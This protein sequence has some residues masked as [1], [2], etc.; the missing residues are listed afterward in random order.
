VL[1][2]LV[3]LDAEGIDSASFQL[4]NFPHQLF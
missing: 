4:L 1:H 2:A 3:P